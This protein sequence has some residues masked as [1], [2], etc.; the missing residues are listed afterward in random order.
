MT[1]IENIY[2]RYPF[3]NLAQTL[4]NPFDQIR[5]IDWTLFLPNTTLACTLS[6][7]TAQPCSKHAVIALRGYHQTMR[8]AGFL[9]L[10]SGWGVVIAAV[11]L[12][13]GVARAGFVAAGLGVE[14]LGF[15]LVIR[16]H[17]VLEDERG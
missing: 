14:A 1:A 13:A 5:K 10:L 15:V 11:A 2:A 7:R 4:G 8:L 6:G 9:L 12:L 16:S 17:L 3:S